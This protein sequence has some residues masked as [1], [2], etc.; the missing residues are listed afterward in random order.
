MGTYRSRTWK[1]DTIGATGTILMQSFQEWR[2][3]RV[4]AKSRTPL[5]ICASVCS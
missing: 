4:R 1:G 2:M 3:K 5:H